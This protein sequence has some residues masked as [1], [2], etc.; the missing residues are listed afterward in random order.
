MMSDTISIQQHELLQNPPSSSPLTT[1]TLEHDLC[2][3]A[4][5]GVVIPGK[6]SDAAAI[7]CRVS[8]PPMKG[9]FVSSSPVAGLFT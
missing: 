8:T 3:K 2:K 1:P 5:T 9:T 6:A 4:N 7:A